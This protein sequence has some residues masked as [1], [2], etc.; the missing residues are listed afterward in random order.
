MNLDNKYEAW[1]VH[2]SCDLTTYNPGA[3][4]KVT[5]V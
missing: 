2:S 3:A 1:C 4:A 5:N